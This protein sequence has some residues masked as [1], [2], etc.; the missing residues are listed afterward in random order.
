MKI[1]Q[2]DIG[3]SFSTSKKRFLHK[4]TIHNMFTTELEYPYWQRT[5]SLLA[6][7]YGLDTKETF[8]EAAFAQKGINTDFFIELLHL[9]NTESELPIEQFKTFPIPIILDYLQKTHH[10][11]LNKKLLE[12]EQSISNLRNQ[13][14]ENHLLPF[15]ENFFVWIK[16]NLTFHIRM[17]EEQ[18]FPHILALYLKVKDKKGFSIQQ[19]IENHA[20]TVELQLSEVKKHIVRAQSSVSEIFP[21][22]VLLKQLDEFEKDL[23]I[24]AKIEDEV[25]IP[26]S[27]ELE[28]TNK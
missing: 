1:R 26:I 20:D 22:R 28:L 4:S 18:L 8:E 15:L 3:H 27:L 23:R 9:F 6:Q 24:H 17:E 7:R 12:I 13:L 19:F 5:V 10:Y 11:Y 25:L 16:E 14:P 21:F 2:N